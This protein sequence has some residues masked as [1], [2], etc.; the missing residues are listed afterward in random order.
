MRLRLLILSILPLWA[1]EPRVVRYE[2]GLDDLKF[3][4]AQMPE[5]L[6]LK[7][8]DIIETKTV[9]AEGKAFEARGRKAKGPNPLTGPFFIEGAQP[10]DTLV[11]RFLSMT[12]EGNEGYGGAGPGFGALNSTT[13]TPML[14]GGIPKRNWT[15]RIDKT[16]NSAVFKANDSDF[17]VKIPLRPFLGCVG[18]APAMAEARSSIVPAEFGGNMDASEAS[19]GNTLYLPV[20]VPGALLLLGVGLGVMGGAGV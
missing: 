20:N 5:A 4:Y 7:P 12:V 10:G 11:V 3:V 15:Y 6:R 8:G 14:G 16:S 9:D 2:P 19:P 13:Y 18:V 1:A 17:S